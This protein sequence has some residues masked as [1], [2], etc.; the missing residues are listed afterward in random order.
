MRA[1]DIK[2][3]TVGQDFIEVRKGTGARALR[4]MLEKA[5]LDVMYEVPS[6]RR[7]AEFKL[8]RQFLE[9]HAGSPAAAA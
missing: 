1:I 8:T 9:K 4:A 2:T 6:R 3:T 5:M 7:P